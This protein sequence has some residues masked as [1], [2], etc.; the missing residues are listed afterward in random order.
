[1]RKVERAGRSDESGMQYKRREIL[2]S[3]ASAANVQPG[4]HMRNPAQ[5]G[6]AT[7]LH[8]R[9]TFKAS[10]CR[11]EVMDNSQR[12]YDGFLRGLDFNI[13]VLAR[14]GV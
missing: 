4:R 13:L 5:E 6:T 14:V 3:E 7:E 11:L 10:P 9:Q 1:M 8:A 12:G 2:D